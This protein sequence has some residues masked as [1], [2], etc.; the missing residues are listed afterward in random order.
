MKRILPL[1]TLL[2]GLVF[3]QVPAYPE[4]TAGLGF[5]VGKNLTVQAGF[6][7]PLLGLDTGLDLELNPLAAGGVEVWTLSRLNL[8]PAL[9]VGDLSMSVGAGLELRYAAKNGATAPSFGAHL[10]PTATLELPGSAL[11]AYVGL[12]YQG[13]FSLAYGVGFRAYLDPIALEIALTDR[14]WLKLS[15]LYLW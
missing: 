9:V 5:T 12:G 7:L 3:A 8:I 10:G 15:A 2:C 6:N 11:S 13:G 14:Y 4:N 1:L